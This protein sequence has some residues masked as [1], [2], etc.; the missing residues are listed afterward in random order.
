MTERSPNPIEAAIDQYSD[1]LQTREDIETFE[2]GYQ[3]G[4]QYLAT[5]PPEQ[6]P[7]DPYEAVLACRRAYPSSDQYT[8]RQASTIFGIMAVFRGQQGEPQ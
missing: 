3:H 2:A 7:N 6:I 8:P 4:E 5:T 1:V